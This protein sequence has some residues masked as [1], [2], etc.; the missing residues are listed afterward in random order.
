MENALDAH[1][2]K[3]GDRFIFPYSDSP[4][5]VRVIGEQ[6]P[7]KDFFGREGHIKYLCKREDTGKQGYMS[8]GPG[9]IPLQPAPP[10][11]T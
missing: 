4:V 3:T 9:A 2:L 5:T 7:A 11:S 10:E 1:S 8:F 6:E